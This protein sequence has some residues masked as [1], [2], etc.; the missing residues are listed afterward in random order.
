M[1]PQS[2]SELYSIFLPICRSD[3]SSTLHRAGFSSNRPSSCCLWTKQTD[4]VYS[5]K[6]LEKQKQT[7]SLFPIG[8]FLFKANNKDTRTIRIVIVLI[9]LFPTLNRYLPTKILPFL[10]A[11][12]QKMICSKY[13]IETE[14][15]CTVFKVR[16]LTL[17]Y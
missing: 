12:S 3:G 1:I 5:V 16:N 6:L 4:N 13:E 2:F 9:L 15:L 17:Y 7:R 14:Y 11:N 8:Q 10:D